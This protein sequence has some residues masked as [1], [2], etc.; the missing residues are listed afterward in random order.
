MPDK[1]T[2]FMAHVASYVVAHLKLI[3][4]YKELTSVQLGKPFIG[5]VRNVLVHTNMYIARYV[6]GSI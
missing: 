3:D 4:C 6:I 1:T 5:F 2:V